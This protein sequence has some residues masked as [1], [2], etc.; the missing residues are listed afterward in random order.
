MK[1]R[2]LLALLFAVSLLC[3]AFFTLSSCSIPTRYELS[4]MF[5]DQYSVGGG[6]Y[7]YQDVGKIEINWGAGDIT[8]LHGEEERMAFFESASSLTEAQQMHT[9]ISGGV[10]Y[11]QYCESEYYGSIPAEQKNLTLYIPAGM[12]LDLSCVSGTVKMD[13]VEFEN[14]RID[15]SSAQLS[16][17]KVEF[18]SML[19]YN[20]SGDLTADKL[21]GRDLY[22]SATS[23]SMRVKDMSVTHPWI[24]LV[25]GDVEI[26]ALTATDFEIYTTSGDV[27]LTMAQDTTGTIDTVSGNVALTLPEI[28]NLTVRY[29]SVSGEL[30]TQ[31][32]C[33]MS[34][35]DEYAYGN[36][37]FGMIAIS[38]TSGNV[39]IR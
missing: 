20:T 19:I 26:P 9:L 1:Y 18:D 11:I 5:A 13:G 12:S 35:I 32:A 31:R 22:Y 14:A 30:V 21:E 17:G 24:E 28:S 38:T 8:I 3:V 2:R 27:A 7:Y 15:T 29:E 37:A 25:S 39:E 16:F 33:T 34:K 36:G 10:L 4:Y 23:G 6:D